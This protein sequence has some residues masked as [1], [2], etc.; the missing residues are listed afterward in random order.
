MLNKKNL[1]WKN[2]Q[3][4]YKIR[5]ISRWETFNLEHKDF[6]YWHWAS[7]NN[8]IYTTWKPPYYQ[9]RPFWR[10]Y[11]LLAILFSLHFLSHFRKTNIHDRRLSTRKIPLLHETVHFHKKWLTYTKDRPF[12]PKTAHFDIRRFIYNN[13]V[14]LFKHRSGQFEL[15]T[16]HFEKKRPFS[17]MIFRFYKLPSTFSYEFPYLH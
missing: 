16:V 7:R 4:I 12:L 8:L 2:F 13:T 3:K 14:P 9:Y 11:F 17:N 5:I 15:E 1:F 6:K 10:S